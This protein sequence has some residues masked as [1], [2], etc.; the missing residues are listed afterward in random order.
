MGGHFFST[1]N[2]AFPYSF[3]DW[4]YVS[5]DRGN[6]FFSFITL[7][8]E[9]QRLFKIFTKD[10]SSLLNLV[11]SSNMNFQTALRD[12]GEVTLVTLKTSFSLRPG[13]R[14][15]E[16]GAIAEAAAC[17]SMSLHQALVI[18]KK[19]LQP[20]LLAPLLPPLSWWGWRW[21]GR[22]GWTGSWCGWLQ[23]CGN[24]PFAVL[25]QERAL[26]TPL[27]HP[28]PA[29][30]ERRIHKGQSH[31]RRVFAGHCKLKGLSEEIRNFQQ[32]LNLHVHL[33][34]LEWS[35]HYGLSFHIWISWIV[36]VHDHCS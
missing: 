2:S 11:V 33:A 31:T 22:Q 9:V 34:R 26:N 1:K 15:E 3:K 27:H 21:W 24:L 13:L 7:L 8:W 16:A 35:W 32:S 30:E 29:W 17:C 36:I 12:W 25:Q 6:V 23:H 4:R 28:L 10:L 5:I 19:S 20:F 14:F 18:V